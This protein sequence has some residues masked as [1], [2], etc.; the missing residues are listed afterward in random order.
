M[1]EKRSHIRLN[2]LQRGNAL[3]RGG[4]VNKQIIEFKFFFCKFSLHWALGRFSRIIV[5][6][7]CLFVCLLNLKIP[8]CEGQK[9]LLVE[10]PIA[11]FDLRWQ[12]FCFVF[13]SMI[14]F[15]WTRRK[16]K[17]W[18]PFLKKNKCYRC[19]YQHWLRDSMSPVAGFLLTVFSSWRW[20]H[21][22]HQWRYSV[23]PICRIF[24]RGLADY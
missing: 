20:W 17:C 2:A 8:T 13:I 24:Q 18:T 1:S 19:Y 7:V 11:N 10:G 12:N 6:S 22:P 5:M 23:S 14:K 15:C 4:R 21:Y 16:K 3:N 9:K